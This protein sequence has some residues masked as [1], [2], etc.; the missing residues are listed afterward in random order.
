[1]T[2]RRWKP[3]NITL[4]DAKAIAHLVKRGVLKIGLI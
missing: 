2:K 4:S 1:M 3:E